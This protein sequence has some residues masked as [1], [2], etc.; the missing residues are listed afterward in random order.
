MPDVWRGNRKP[1]DEDAPPP[2]VEM[3]LAR[4]RMKTAGAAREDTAAAVAS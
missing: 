4:T 2:Y 1:T 3:G